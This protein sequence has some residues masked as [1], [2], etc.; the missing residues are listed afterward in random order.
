MRSSIL[1]VVVILLSAA[2]QRCAPVEELQAPDAS[3]LDDALVDAGTTSDAGAS[4]TGAIDTGLSDS[5]VEETMVEV[6][7]RCAPANGAIVLVHDADGALISQVVAG[8]DGRAAVQVPPRNLITAIDR[9]AGRRTFAGT[10]A[11]VAPGEHVTLGLVAL[12]ANAS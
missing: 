7:R 4:D 10:I 1:P 8:A 9:V 2:I 12:S 11:D 5:G 3:T 6:V